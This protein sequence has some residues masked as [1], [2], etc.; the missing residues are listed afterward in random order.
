[1]VVQGRHVHAYLILVLVLA[2]M[3]LAEDELN[4]IE[5]L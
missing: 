4:A 2:A 1:M 3:L 5:S